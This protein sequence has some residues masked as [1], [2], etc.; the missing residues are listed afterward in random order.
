M[1]TSE[2]IQRKHPHQGEAQWQ[3]EKLGFG[4]V[5]TYGFRSRAVWAAACEVLD[6]SVSVPL[7]P[8][9]YNRKSGT[10]LV[11]IWGTDVS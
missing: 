2:I 1:G 4:G 7:C 3:Q 11:G 5:S 6:L 8:R 9:V 10:S